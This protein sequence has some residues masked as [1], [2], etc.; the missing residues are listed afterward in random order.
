MN[1]T[2]RYRILELIGKGGF[3]TVYRAELLTAGGFRKPVA[4][5]VLNAEMA[6][7]EEVVN[8]LKD[9]ARLLA[10]VHH[11]GL[12]QVDSLVQFKGRWAMVMEYIPG[13]GLN[14]LIRRSGIPARCALELIGRV[15]DALHAAHT[16]ADGDRPL[17]LVHRDMK[18][19]NILVGPSGEVKVLDFGIARADFETR[20]SDTE[21][22]L[23]G[24]PEYM[25]PE[26][27]ES[28]DSAASDIFALGLIL[29]EML[30]GGQFG[31]TYPG[32][33]SHQRRLLNALENL[34]SKVPP[35]A[36]ALLRAMLAYN[37][38]ERPAARGV[39]ILCREICSRMEG[40]W[41][42]DWSEQVIAQVVAQRLPVQGDSLTGTVIVEHTGT[43][44]FPELSEPGQARGQVPKGTLAILGVL[45]LVGAFAGFQAWKAWRELGAGA[46][47]EPPTQIQ[48]VEVESPIPPPP[49]VPVEV[50]VLETLPADPK[51]QVTSSEPTSGPRDAKPPS[52]TTTSKPPSSQP[53]ADAGPKGKVVV[54][55]DAQR[56]LLVRGSVHL[57][58]GEVPAG[59]YSIM[60]TFPGTEPAV[61]GQVTVKAN[62]TLTLSCSSS[63]ALCQVKR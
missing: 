23:F 62:E 41:L 60:A 18:P 48:K 37:P 5:K 16:A 24:S 10:F 33:E 46:S 1:E 49:V 26:R 51:P 4:L 11:P 8:R 20:E 17:A 61:A 59:S 30:A 21:E 44:G 14:E 29:Y 35:H 34:S 52:T 9:E 7:S 31:R 13:S 39:E 63:F 53:P 42:R 6:N 50:R 58:P 3:G 32:L 19:S 25:A 2:R 45:V 54:I 28:K 43:V 27:W 56:V 15:A 12:V 22:M 38:E 36:L 55:G 47:D 40:P 57:S